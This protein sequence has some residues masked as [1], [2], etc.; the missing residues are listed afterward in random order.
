VWSS[1]RA[2]HTLAVLRERRAALAF[3]LLRSL[4]LELLVL[5]RFPNSKA[6]FRP[7]ATALVLALG[8]ILPHVAP[9]SLAPG[10]HCL[11]RPRAQAGLG[12]RGLLRVATA[13]SRLEGRGWAYQAAGV[14][15][16][17]ALQLNMVNADLL[18]TIDSVELEKMKVAGLKELCEACGLTKTGKK[19]D[20]VARILDL[21][22]ATMAPEFPAALGEFEDDEEMEYREPDEV[23]GMANPAPARMFDADGVPL[24]RE[25]LPDLASG[26]SRFVAQPRTGN[27]WHGLYFD[28]QAKDKP[29]TVTAIRTASSPEGSAPIREDKM[30][31]FIYT[32]EGSVVGQELVQDAWTLRGEEMGIQLPVVSYG[33]SDP[34]YGSVPL[35]TP[36][37]IAKGAT[38]GICLFSSSWRGVIL[39]AKLGEATGW[40]TGEVTDEN[41]D[42]SLHA[43]V[44][45][46]NDEA[47]ADT[48]FTKVSLSLSFFLYCWLTH[49]QTLLHAR[50]CACSLTVN[51]SRA[52]SCSLARSLFLL[53]SW[54]CD[55]IITTISYQRAVDVAL[56]VLR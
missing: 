23:Y 16:R 13:Q 2:S 32:C 45:P 17:G 49:S 1:I 52:L 42:L 53:Y 30:N 15:A 28:I 56:A 24:V 34:F 35:D 40:Q 20:L 5:S 50:A 46:R 18:Q 39:R 12:S 11:Q 7:T 44:L 27:C 6:M 4:N 48:M 55:T 33:E 9:Y 29:I 10:I 37:K 47:Y 51:L 54:C 8:S 43:G 26:T 21:Q 41:D 22:A 38:V 31:L 3:F 14:R 36:I 19:A 25:F